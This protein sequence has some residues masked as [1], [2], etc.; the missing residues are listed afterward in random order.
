VKIRIPF[1]TPDA[2]EFALAEATS[3]ICDQ[4][5]RHD[6]QDRYSDTIDKFVK[7]GECITIEFDTDLGTATVVPVR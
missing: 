3:D 1:K 7:Y 4:D 2:V 6:F 5:L